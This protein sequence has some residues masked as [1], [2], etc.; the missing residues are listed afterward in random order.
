M[1]YFIISISLHRKKEYFVTNNVRQTDSEVLIQ[2]SFLRI[3]KISEI[4][5]KACWPR[6]IL[7]NFVETTYSCLSSFRDSI[8]TIRKCVM[9]V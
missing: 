6:A 4:K 8:N 2:D 1:A 3:M 7:F 5:S 9:K